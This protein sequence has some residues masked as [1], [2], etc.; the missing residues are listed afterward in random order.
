MNSN[1]STLL[2]TNKPMLHQS[3]SHK[4]I[5]VDSEWKLILERCPKKQSLLKRNKSNLK[6]KCIDGVTKMTNSREVHS[7]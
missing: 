3:S 5:S 7:K 6:Y 2:Y 4:T 1:L